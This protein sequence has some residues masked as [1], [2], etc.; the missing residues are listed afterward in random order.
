ADRMA[1]GR[2]HPVRHEVR[3]LEPG[4]L[5]R[6]DQLLTG[7][8]SLVGVLAA[9]VGSDDTDLALDRRDP[10]AEGEDNL[11]RWRGHH[12]AHGRARADEDRVGARRTTGPEQQ[13]G[14]NSEAD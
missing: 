4:S 13:E 14:S 10:L 12:A 1:V 3:A 9:A 8:A 2:D 5:Q 11:V 7:G 6:D